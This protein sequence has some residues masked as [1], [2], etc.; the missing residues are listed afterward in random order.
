MAISIQTSLYKT[1][2]AENFVQETIDNDYYLFASTNEVALNTLE[3][4]SDI[5]EKAIFGKAVDQVVY[6]IKDNRWTTGTVYPVYAPD[7]DIVTSLHYMVTYPADSGSG[8]YQVFKCLSNNNGGPSTVV[9][10]YLVSNTSQ[11]YLT[12]D[13]YI[14]KYMYTI[15]EA[16][17]A[18][19]SVFG[20]IPVNQ[21]S[22]TPIADR[23][24]GSI[25]I[26]NPTSN[27]GYQPASG[28]V[29]TVFSDRIILSGTTLSEVADFYN[30]QIITITSP[31]GVSTVYNVIDYSYSIPFAEATIFIQ[32]TITGLIV[33]GH[34]F[35]ITPKILIEGD[36]T[37]AIAIPFF[38]DGSLRRVVMISEGAGYTRARATVV[39]P[40]LGFNPETQVGLQEDAL[41]EVALS[42]VGGHGSNVRRELGCKNLLVYTKIEEIDNNNIQQSGSFES[43]ALVRNPDFRTPV[44]NAFD[45]RLRLTLAGT[46]GLAVGQELYQLNGSSQEVFR[47]VVQEIV[48]NDVYVI[49]Y[50]RFYPNTLYADIS[51]VP[52]FS[53]INQNNQI[54]T[55]NTVTL[56][57]YLQKTGEMIYSASVDEIVRTITSREEFKIMLN[58]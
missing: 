9:P 17:F 52:T 13:G 35:R 4:Q 47:G 7:A 10:S 58:F 50:N 28:V 34:T 3:S 20:Y 40:T 16:D 14:W 57:A 46:S 44:T 49:D 15:S 2:L 53:L 19:Y 27:R 31:S 48:G 32:E 18:R 56:P 51:L 25:L 41:L 29:K 43:V 12:G 24:V 21:P 30:G 33:S 22:V 39:R 38:E 11:V 8:N 54:F 55:I 42:P 45:N 26:T 23:G 6:M 1:I 36:G 5:I 37:G